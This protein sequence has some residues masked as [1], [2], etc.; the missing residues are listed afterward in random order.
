MSLSDKILTINELIR[1]VK[2]KSGT[3]GGWPQYLKCEI[4]NDSITISLDSHL[5][6]KKA[7]RRVDPW[8]LAFLVYS[9]SRCSLEIH[10]IKFSISGDTN[11][12]WIQNRIAPNIEAFHRRVSFL[13]I[14][15]IG[16]SFEIDINHEPLS[17]YT[18]DSLFNRPVDEIIRTNLN[19]PQDNQV[20][21]LEKNF[22]TWLN[23][24]DVKDAQQCAQI[25]QILD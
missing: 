10:R 8:G 9:E 1:E 21:R 7:M 24:N 22:Q 11:D 13:N 16:L 4:K 18:K 5:D 25:T 15:N 12:I 20:G 6:N 19:K 17:L 3:A 23:A 2:S 14:N